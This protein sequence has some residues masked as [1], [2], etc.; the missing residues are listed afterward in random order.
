[1]LI[2]CN[3]DK[4]QWHSVTHPSGKKLLHWQSLKVCKRFPR[5]L[6]RWWFTTKRHYIGCMYLYLS[7]DLRG[8]LPNLEYHWKTRRLVK[9]RR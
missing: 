4:V 7:Q 8:T 9:S 6:L 2:E 5:A 1:M 3:N